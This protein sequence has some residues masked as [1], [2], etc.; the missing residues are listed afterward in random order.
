MSHK[1]KQKMPFSDLKHRLFGRLISSRDRNKLFERN[2]LEHEHL[3]KKADSIGLTDIATREGDLMQKRRSLTD[4]AQSLITSHTLDKSMLSNLRQ[5][6]SQLGLLSREERIIAKMRETLIRS[7]MSKEAELTTV[8]LERNI[9][10]EHDRAKL[11]RWTRPPISSV[12][13]KMDKLQLQKEMDQDLV[14]DYV[15][16]L[17]DTMEDVEE[18]EGV[19][20]EM[21]SQFLE[22]LQSLQSEKVQEK[23]INCMEGLEERIQS[24]KIK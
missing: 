10:A 15:S 4:M 21:E 18:K 16:S 9:L 20:D 11:R 23:G 8:M 2:I 3:L 24:L 17:S 1:T 6:Y 19:V 5:I 12:T 22:W 7:K 13:R 14:R